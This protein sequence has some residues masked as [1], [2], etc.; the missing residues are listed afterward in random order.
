MVKQYVTKIHRQHTTVVT[1]IPKPVQKA[2]ELTS[3]D[4]LVWQVDSTSVL[5]KLRI[6]VIRGNTHGR[7]KKHSDRKDKGR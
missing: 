6:L 7:G 5:V 1:S 2:F 4:Y 3:A